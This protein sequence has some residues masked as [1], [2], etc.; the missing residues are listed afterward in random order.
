[1]T[2]YPELL[3][4]ECF[5]FTDHT[6]GTVAMVIV[7]ANAQGRVMRPDGL[8]RNWGFDSFCPT[9]DPWR[10]RGVERL[11]HY[12]THPSPTPKHG[13]LRRKDIVIGDCFQYIDDEKNRGKKY[14]AKD[15]SMPLSTPEGWCTSDNCDG[16][17]A[18]VAG[19]RR[20][21]RIPHWNTAP[22]PAPADITTK[23]YSVAMPPVELLDLLLADKTSGL[24]GEVCLA[25]FEMAQQ[26]ESLVRL[27]NGGHVCT[28]AAC[29]LN[30]TQV[31][32]AMRIW[33]LMLKRRTQQAAR[34]E[35]HRVTC[36]PVDEMPN[37]ADA[38]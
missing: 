13:D 10:T 9:Y 14:I 16:T 4:G 28:N 22:A 33:P 26:T 35:L 17:M 15:S 37:M 18:G 6:H 11:E 8:P 19:E 24:T 1:M 5:R 7:A 20:V 27:A 2:L 21:F 30:S 36:D 31:A 12:S 25:R 29:A 38:P 34:R 23:P 3:A 32:F